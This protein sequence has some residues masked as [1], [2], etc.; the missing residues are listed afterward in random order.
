[1]PLKV[2]KAI[3]WLDSD[4]TEGGAYRMIRALDKAREYWPESKV[5]VCTVD[6]VAYVVLCNKKSV[7]VRRNI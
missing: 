1:M 3:L 5:C 4:D 7:T 6:G 2:L